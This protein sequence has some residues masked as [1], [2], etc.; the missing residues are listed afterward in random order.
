MSY[1][2]TYVPEPGTTYTAVQARELAAM[3]EGDEKRQDGHGRDIIYI[4]TG[5]T[6]VLIATLWDYAARVEAAE[7]KRRREIEA[8]R[9][10]ELGIVIESISTV[11]GLVTEIDLEMPFEHMPDLIEMVQRGAQQLPG[12]RGVVFAAIGSPS[13][14]GFGRVGISLAV[15]HIFMRGR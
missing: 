5:E 8:A 11:D 7:A 14:R 1:D 10:A 9:A 2:R 13:L 3:L 12:A 15:D 4:G 6:D